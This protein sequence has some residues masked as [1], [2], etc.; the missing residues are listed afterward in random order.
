MQSDSVP[1]AK[2]ASPAGSVDDA[3]AG[4]ETTEEFERFAFDLLGNTVVVPVVKAI[5]ERV[6]EVISLKEKMKIEQVEDVVIEA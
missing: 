2:T 4:I 3:A 5:A 6:L 1:A